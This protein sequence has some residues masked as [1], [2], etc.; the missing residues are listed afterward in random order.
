MYDEKLLLALDQELQLQVGRSDERPLHVLPDLPFITVYM[1]SNLVVSKSRLIFLVIEQY[2]NFLRHTPAAEDQDLSVPLTNGHTIPETQVNGDAIQ[3]DSTTKFM[4]NPAVREA[5]DACKIMKKKSNSNRAPDP[6]VRRC[7][8]PYQTVDHED[9]EHDFTTP[10]IQGSLECPFAK[11]AAQNGLP[12]LSPNGITDPIAAEFHQDHISVNSAPPS[13]QA[14]GK[15]PIRFLDQH[16]PEEV[17]KYF[18]NHKHEIPRSHEICVKRYQQN[19]QSIR[20]LDAKYGNLV[21]M[22]QGLGVKHKQYLPEEETSEHRHNDSVEGVEKWADTIS[23]KAED[24][25]G[26][27]EQLLDGLPDHEV[28]RKPHFERPLREIRVGES[29][30]RPWGISV[31]AA[32]KPSE[33]AILSD[34]GTEP[35]SLARSDE[36]TVPK[37]VQA[38]P[39][40]QCPVDHGQRNGIPLAAEQETA[41]RRVEGN[42]DKRGTSQPQIVFNGPVFF[43]YSAEQAAVLLQS[44][45]FG[46]GHH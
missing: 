34:R 7:P 15:C 22:I 44:A 16:S 8:V 43:G 13:A 26:G 37:S 21:N 5:I 10:G 33:S 20:Q 38:K 41:T 3:A 23:H 18:E 39:V 29:P 9:F 36:I 28:E 40:G 2:N 42:H 6:S 27:D 19:E 4:S 25:A 30:S 32:Q 24:P 31:P 11:M 45:E 12:S 1:L 35:V 14:T 17:A 46:A